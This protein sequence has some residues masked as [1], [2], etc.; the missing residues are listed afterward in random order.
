MIWNTLSRL[1]FPTRTIMTTSSP[2]AGRDDPQDR[3]RAGSSA[4][5]L[6]LPPVRGEAPQDVRSPARDGNSVVPLISAAEVYPALERALLR[7]RDTAHLSFRILDPSMRTVSEEARGRGLTDWAGLFIDAARRGVHVRFLLSDFDPIM[8]ADLHRLSW[9]SYLRL[10][11]DAADLPEEA[12]RR[13]E[14]MTSLH[15][16]KAGSAM[17]ALFWPVVWRRLSGLAVAL[18]GDT[19]HTIGKAPH[20]LTRSLREE[21][22]ILL[23]EL[24]GVWRLVSR[25]IDIAPE[26]WSDYLTRSAKSGSLSRLRAPFWPPAH[27]W[28]VTHHQKLALFDG[29][30]MIVGGL[31][32]NERRYDDRQHDRHA[33]D[34]WHDVSIR[35]HGPIVADAEAHFRRTW[36]NERE[37]FLE[38]REDLQPLLGADRGLVSPTTLSDA[39]ARDAST[40][41]PSTDAADQDAE[42]PKVRAQF[43]RT[44]SRRRMGPFAFTPVSV[45]RD[46]EAGHHAVIEAAHK[47]LYIETQFFR[48]RSLSRAIIRQAK[49]HPDLKVIILLPNAPEDIAWDDNEAVDATHGEFLQVRALGLLKRNLKDRLGLYMLRQRRREDD[50]EGRA[51]A[52]GTGII[53]L[54]SKVIIADDRAA[55]V[56]SANMNGRSFRWDTEAG[57]LFEQT[58]EAG[59]VRDL[60]RGLFDTHLP[61]DADSQWPLETS[62]DAW[63]TLNKADMA[64]PVAERRNFIAPY[65]IGRARRFARRSA[66]IPDDMI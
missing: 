34:A 22:N 32:V 1:S 10:H 65:Q 16:A 61:R 62:F 7:A 63:R 11:E 40:R 33:E 44:V 31:D 42:A 29:R 57:V 58:G 48:L 25:V 46:L 5:D 54:H 8:A 51:R 38:L 14:V 20:E 56:S 6:F 41:Q 66:F 19:R 53:Y 15:E 39:E 47:L 27:L 64:R 30:E 43:L 26:E 12:W 4:A 9:R 59:P 23:R 36:N 21:E 52:F 24:P 13:L 60:R 55:L 35:V 28:P 50:E 2:P 17:R 49:R 37:R 45:R 18:R 3:A